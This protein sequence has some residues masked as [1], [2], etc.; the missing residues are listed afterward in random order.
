MAGITAKVAVVNQKYSIKS[1]FNCLKLLARNGF[2]QANDTT[3]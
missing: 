3:P 1:L 2:V